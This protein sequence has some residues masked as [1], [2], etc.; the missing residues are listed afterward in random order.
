MSN[1]GTI[2]SLFPSKKPIFQ[3]FL[4]TSQNRQQLRGHISRSKFGRRIQCVATIYREIEQSSFDLFS[5]AEV[6]SKS[7]EMLSSHS[8]VDSRGITHANADVYSEF[9]P[10]STKDAEDNNMQ[11]VTDSGPVKS[12]DLLSL[13]GWLRLLQKVQS[14]FCHI[15]L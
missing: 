5:T 15:Q 13:L 4:F 10:V 8:I 7:A 6:A 1:L 14:C 3:F 12:K 11:Q 2:P 9:F